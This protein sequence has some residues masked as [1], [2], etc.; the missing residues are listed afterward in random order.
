LEG[1]IQAQGEAVPPPSE[2]PH[3][4]VH[5]HNGFAS[6]FLPGERDVTVYVPPGYEEEP[7]RRY[8]LLLLQDGQNLFDP[9]TSFIRGRTWRVAENADEAIVAGDVEPLVIVGVQNAG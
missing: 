7:G 1:Q 8:P 2:P 4:R 6:R 3:P 9:E 5:K